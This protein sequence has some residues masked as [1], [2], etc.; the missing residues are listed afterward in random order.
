MTVR[1][2]PRLTVCAAAATSAVIL[3]AFI[4]AAPAQA[5]TA[6][7]AAPASL[8]ALAGNGDAVLDVVMLV[9]ESGS[10]TNANVAAER[11]TAGTIAQALLNPR[12]RVTVVG[13]GGVNHVAPDQDPVNVACQPTIASGAVN[14]SYLASCVN[15]LHRRTEAEGDDTDYAAALGQAMS[16][17]SP[18]T[19]YGR[20]SPAGAIKVILMMTDGGVDVHRDTQQYGTNWLAGVHHAVN[21][22]LAAARADGVQVWP[23]G[24]GTIL[25]VD[26]QY[27]NYLAANGAQTACDNRQV[28]RPHA[29][30]VNNPAKA[31]AAL[32]ALYASACCLGSNSSSVSISSNQTRWLQ[33]SI[34]P[35]ASDAVISVDRGNPGIQVELLHAERPAVDGLVGDQWDDN[36]GGG[37]ARHEPA[38]RGMAD[39]AHCA[40]G[41]RQPAGHR[42][43]VLA[44]RC[45][46]AHAR[47]PRAARS[48]A[49][50][51][52]SR[53]ACWAR[54]AR[55]PTR[56]R[57]RRC[58]PR[59]ASRVTGCPARPRS[60]SATPASKA[61]RPA[62][63]IT[64]VR[65]PRRRRTGR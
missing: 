55:S 13:F 23:L 44:G 57:S 20:Q 50:P 28:S 3:L 43:R 22:Q 46:R 32:D 27:L 9:D 25:P 14:L 19:A 64:R 16:Y 1:R 49:S 38:A 2:V 29:T 48:P 62:W 5:L 53:S 37:P 33:V 30:I 42:D 15:S 58:R 11:Q 47:P 18:D 7:G 60:R 12:S 40:A 4:A 36:R 31:L 21:L 59:S 17:F 8:A 26:Q 6:V 24:F 61:R 56:R 54:T 34:P 52:T 63:A 39:Q 10:E 45:G 65:S 41:A 51:S 35:I